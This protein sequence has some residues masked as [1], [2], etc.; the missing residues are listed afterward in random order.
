MCRSGVPVASVLV[1]QPT[2]RILTALLHELTLLS[3]DSKLL[4]RYYFPEHEGFVRLDQRYLS[5]LDLEHGHAVRGYVGGVLR[6]GLLVGMCPQ[7]AD[8]GDARQAEVSGVE[9]NLCRGVAT[10]E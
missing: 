9:A 3:C 10:V 2:P 6:C 7:V 4:R 5:P 1:R 8:L